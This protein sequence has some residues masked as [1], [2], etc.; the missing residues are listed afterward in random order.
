VKCGK[1]DS[2]KILR[3]VPKHGIDPLVPEALL[4]P[5]S[6]SAPWISTVSLRLSIILSVSD[7]LADREGSQF[8]LKKLNPDQHL[9]K[10]VSLNAGFAKTEYTVLIRIRHA[11]E[12]SPV[13]SARYPNTVFRKETSGNE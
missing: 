9:L 12:S 7:D 8:Q 10:P 13:D 11:I 1:S 5:T 4:L 6:L 3:S 2:S